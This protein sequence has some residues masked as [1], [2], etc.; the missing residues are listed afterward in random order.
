MTTNANALSTLSPLRGHWPKGSTV[1]HLILKRVRPSHLYTFFTY[2]LERN[3]SS[4]IP[5]HSWPHCRE[6][7]M[8]RYER[9]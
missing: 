8:S 7:K 6:G 4:S 3:A 2:C 5:E 1:F 9:L